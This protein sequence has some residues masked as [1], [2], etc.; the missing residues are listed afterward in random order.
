MAKTQ[1]IYKRLPGRGLAAMQNVRLYRGPDHL[2]Q[3]SSTGF[4]EAY[5]RFYFRDVQAITIQKTH[6]GKF[7]NGF[8]ALLVFIF[9]LSASGMSGGAAIAMWIIAGFFGL[10]LLGNTIAGPT[11]ACYI[12]SAVQTERL[13]PVNRIRTARR[14]LKRI[15]PFI[16]EQQGAVAREDLLVRMAGA[17]PTPT[18]PVDAPPVISAETPPS[19]TA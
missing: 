2:L 13:T 4:S 6:A 1:K 18:N 14:L 17:K 9:G 8:W 3:L 5:K 7:V 15:R 19:Q 16:D 11:C 10:C 12:R